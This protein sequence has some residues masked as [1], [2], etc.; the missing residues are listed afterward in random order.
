[1]AAVIQ[2]DRSLAAPRGSS[3]EA[4]RHSAAASEA[5]SAETVDCAGGNARSVPARPAVCHPE[6]TLDA[7]TTRRVTDPMGA[8]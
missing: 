8:L 2:G 4:V 3:R 5:A 7:S 1:M 6:W